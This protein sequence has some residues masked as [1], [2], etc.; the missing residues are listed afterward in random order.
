[1]AI[2]TI[3]NKRKRKGGKKSNRRTYK[4]RG[5]NKTIL[6]LITISIMVTLGMIYLLPEHDAQHLRKHIDVQNGPVYMGIED[7]ETPNTPTIFNFGQQK[8]E[9]SVTS[10]TPTESKIDG[11]KK[12][13]D[14]NNP[15]SATVFNR[16]NFQSKLELAL[17]SYP[18]IKKPVIVTK[19]HL[20]I[21]LDQEYEK[22]FSRLS[23]DSKE[24]ANKVLAKLSISDV[25]TNVNDP[26]GDHIYVIDEGTLNGITDKL[27]NELVNELVNKPVVNNL[28]RVEI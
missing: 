20:I 10:N 6:A 7:S 13:E 18:R 4:Q 21:K 5:G 23:L 27:V 8:S 12:S 26:N 25:V 14:S 15:L 11:D 9:D 2:K 22:I 28:R 3:K 17:K 1:M 16:P 19:D 24:I